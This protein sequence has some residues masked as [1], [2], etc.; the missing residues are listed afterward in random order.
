MKIHLSY[1]MLELVEQII[2]ITIEKITSDSLLVD[3][4]TNILVIQIYLFLYYI[5]LL[6]LGQQPKHINLL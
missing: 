3:L 6:D 4:D 2:V 5:L 1:A